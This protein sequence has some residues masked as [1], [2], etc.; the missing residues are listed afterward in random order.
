MDEQDLS[1]YCAPLTEAVE[2]IGRR[3]TG[4]VLRAVMAGRTRF[5]AIAGAIPGISDRLLSQRLKELE[6]LGAVERNVTP[7]T[8]VAIEYTLTPMGESLIPVLLEIERWAVKWLVPA[9]DARTR[10]LRSSS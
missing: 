1:P 8:P 3:W 2:L 10:R 7:S 5:S 4:S 6:A 9:V